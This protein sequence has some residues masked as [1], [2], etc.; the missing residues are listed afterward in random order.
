M[1]GAVIVHVI[2][3]IKLSLHKL[4]H[5]ETIELFLF[6]GIVHLRLEI[7]YI[8]RETYAE[9]IDFFL[10]LITFKYG[11]TCIKAAQVPKGFKCVRPDR[12]TD[13]VLMLCMLQC[14]PA[15]ALSMKSRST[16]TEKSR[17]SNE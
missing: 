15:S 12:D 1:R 8:F 11:H 10:Q 14:R 2:K 9:H 3:Y 16:S 7:I 5:H 6:L 13:G 4:I 17:N